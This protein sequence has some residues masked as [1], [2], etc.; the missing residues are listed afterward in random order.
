MPRRK[1]A[2]PNVRWDLYIPTTLAAQVELVLMD[3]LRSRAKFGARS[4]LISS[5][6][7]DWL[8]KSSVGQGS[9]LTPDAH[10]DTIHTLTM[11]KGNA[12]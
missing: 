8:A 1:L 7:R 12:T 6:L 4:E 3:P 10:G 11:H 5:L 9:N 2:E